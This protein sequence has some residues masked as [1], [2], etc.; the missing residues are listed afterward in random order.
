MVINQQR[1]K[2]GV[3]SEATNAG[4][5]QQPEPTSSHPINRIVVEVFLRKVVIGL[6]PAK[7]LQ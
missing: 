4:A 5:T 2:P 7:K 6:A 3:M 1:L